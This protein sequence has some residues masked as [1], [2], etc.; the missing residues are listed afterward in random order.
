MCSVLFMLQLNDFPNST[1]FFIRLYICIYIY[2]LG[3]YILSSF[4]QSSSVDED[5]ERR[6]REKALQSLKNKSAKRNVDEE[7]NSS[8]D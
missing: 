5:E 6:L 4:I 7:E 3:C 2:Y 1:R 8:E